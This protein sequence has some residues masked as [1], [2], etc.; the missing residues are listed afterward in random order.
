[1]S[2]P[3][4]IDDDYLA[5]SIIAISWLLAYKVYLGYSTIPK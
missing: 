1:M 4:S 5:S 2:R 3:Y